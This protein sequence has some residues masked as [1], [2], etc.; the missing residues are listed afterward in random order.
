MF[1]F[2]AI[3]KPPPFLSNHVSETHRMSH[4]LSLADVW[5]SYSLFTLLL[6]VFI[7]LA[8]SNVIFRAVFFFKLFSFFK[9]LFIFLGGAGVVS[10]LSLLLFDD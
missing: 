3:S 1:G 6:T 4:V 7:L 8:F 9:L 10:T 2:T 5:N